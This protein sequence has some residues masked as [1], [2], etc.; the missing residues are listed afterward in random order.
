MY[1][2]K[3]VKQIH[4]ALK[5]ISQLCFSHSQEK[6]KTLSK[7]VQE[8]GVF[9]D[10]EYRTQASTKAQGNHDLSVSAV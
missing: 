2:L 1:S 7:G 8:T 5:S 6:K 9:S 10:S 4:D 3:P